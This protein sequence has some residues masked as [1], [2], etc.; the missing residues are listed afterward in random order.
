M[1]LTEQDIRM[2]EALRKSELGKSLVEYIERLEGEICDVRN[3]TEKDSVESAR[4]AA[5]SLREMRSH[6]GT[7][8]GTARA[9]PNE[10]L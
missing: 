8:V 9:E 2:F 3:W 5:R 1:R 7:S 10:F 6:L 4:Q